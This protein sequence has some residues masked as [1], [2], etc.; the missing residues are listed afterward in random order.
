MKKII[1]GFGI[2][3]LVLALLLFQGDQAATKGE[4]VVLYDSANIGVIEKNLTLELKKG[5]N[6][7]PI[8]EIAGLSIEEVT[9]TPM[10]SGVYVLGIV[11]Q[12]TPEKGVYEANTGKEVT[13]KLRSGEE[14]S[15]KLLGLRDGNVVIEGD[16]LYVINPSEI[17][18]L[19]VPGLDN[20]RSQAYAII[21]AEKEGKYSFDLI[22]RVKGIGWSSRYKL[23]I[24]DRAKLIGY[25]VINNPTR[26]KFENAEIALVSGEVSF[27][28]P[29][30]TVY[31]LESGKAG[32]APSVEPQKL[33]AF[34]IYRL[35]TASLN[36]FEKKMI[37][38]IYQEAP[39]KR[40]YLYESYPYGSSNA[41]Y[42]S[43]SF[44][45]EKVLPAGIVEIY[46]DMNGSSILIGER[47]IQHTPKGDILRIGI[48]KDIDLKGTT[49][50]LEEKRGSSYSYYKVKITIENFG[51][52]TKTVIV[53]HYKR[54]MLKTSSV[55]PL[56]ETA[57]Y[58]EFRVTV[59][60][61]EK[62]EI[63]FDYEM[64]Y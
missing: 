30:R 31:A 34:Y 37:P 28:M 32:A 33:E 39:F 42:E 52:E 29:P 47:A 56:D 6:E 50:I 45:T 1:G 60:P 18:Y 46:R 13:V 36:P 15:G 48:G 44:K 14:I 5:I 27:Y 3:I 38:Y 23:Y 24:S 61:G 20:S 2:I 40:E 59:G 11:S 9:L 54:G 26:E 62:K 64:S 21:Q 51:K 4:T 19:K 25:I 10:S 7:V 17:S 12:L 58:V 57:S 22:Y 53:R 8:D 63:V 41:V 49:Q 35:G 43:I 16:R 55:K